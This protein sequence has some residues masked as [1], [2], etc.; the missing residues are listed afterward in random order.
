M[1]IDDHDGEQI[2]L[3]DYLS[4]IRT[5]IPLPLQNRLHD[6][7]LLSMQCVDRNPQHTVSPFWG[8]K[9]FRSAT[10]YR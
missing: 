6:S 5:E 10:I 8:A 3:I 2:G 1:H 4:G 7:P 9:G